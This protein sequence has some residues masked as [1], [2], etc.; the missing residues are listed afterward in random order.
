MAAAIAL[1]GMRCP[2]HEMRSSVSSITRTG[3]SLWYMKLLAHDLCL[4]LF[5]RN[6]HRPRPCPIRQN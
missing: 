4:I 2:N 6:F 1:V 3:Q 5:P